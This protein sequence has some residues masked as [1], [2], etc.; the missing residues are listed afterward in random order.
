MQSRL[1]LIAIVALGLT[2]LYFG[3]AR[4]HVTTIPKSIRDPM[5]EMKPPMPPLPELPPLKIPPL[6]TFEPPVLKPGPLIEP[7]FNP[8]QS[9][10]K[11]ASSADGK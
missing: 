7:T 6:P 5:A 3:L 9:V 8:P 4:P 10:V 1:L 2:A 11:R